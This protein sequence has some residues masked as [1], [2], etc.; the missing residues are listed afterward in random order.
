MDPEKER[1]A[2]EGFQP[3]KC[4]LVDLFGRN[5]PALRWELVGVFLESLIEDELRRQDF[6]A[7]E[8]GRLE[9]FLSEEVD[10]GWVRPLLPEDLAVIVILDGIRGLGEEDRLWKKTP[11]LSKRL[12]NERRLTTI[13]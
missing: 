11:R 3:W 5:V 9:P 1:P 2:L 13:F 6:Q 8:S 10:K 12:Q 7:D 4:P